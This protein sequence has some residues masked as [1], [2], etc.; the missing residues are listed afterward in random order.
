[1][2]ESLGREVYELVLELFL[3]SGMAWLVVFLAARIFRVTDAAWR[4]R[5]HVLP[6]FLPLAIV[7]LT[8]SVVRPL[9][10]GG[11][12]PLAE[13]YLASFVSATSVVAPAFS[14]VAGLLLF[15]ALLRVLRPL[16]AIGLLELEQRR[17]QK[18]TP[19]WLRCD[20]ALR[21]VAA[22]L[23]MAPANLV[24][25]DGGNSG[26]ISVW[27]L[28][29][30]VAVSGPLAASLDDEE[31]ESLLAHEL[32]HIKRNDTVIGVLIGVCRRLLAFS[33]FA[34]SAYQSFVRDREE[35]ADDVAVRSNASPLALASCL[36]KACR[37]SS[38]ARRPRLTLSGIVSTRSSWPV[39]E[40]RIRRLMEH[41]PCNGLGTRALVNLFLG[42][43]GS[44]VALFLLLI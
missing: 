12:M 22:R 17:Q 8:H 32:G 25:T 14:I 21:T 16:A 20:S 38:G 1:M 30:C 31:L 6:L 10:M 9:L 35:A 24:L 3:A 4:A 43:V 2:F 18:G 27:P 33:P 41:L 44:V 19:L 5:F 23:G 28:G 15:L 42:T 40:G 7:P 36:V 13:Y 37:A 26:S 34:R 11:T 39:V 29:S